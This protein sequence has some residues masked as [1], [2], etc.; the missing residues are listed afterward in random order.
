MRGATFFSKGDVILYAK[1]EGGSRLIESYTFFFGGGAGNL[2]YYTCT[3][4]W[5]VNFQKNFEFSWG[6][7]RLD[8]PPPLDKVC[9]C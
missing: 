5:H 1:G 9:A 7:V 4:M 2:I 3:C 8:H 6:C